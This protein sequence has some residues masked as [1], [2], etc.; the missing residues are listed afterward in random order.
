M[1]VSEGVA[2]QPL[3]AL[4]YPLPNEGADMMEQ[5]PVLHLPPG[6]DEE[7]DM[8][9]I[10]H[11]GDDEAV[12]NGSRLPSFSSSSAASFATY[13]QVAPQAETGGARMETDGG[14]ESLPNKRVRTRSPHWPAGATQGMSAGA[15][16]GVVQGQAQSQSL[17]PKSGCSGGV[18]GPFGDN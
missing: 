6:G 18:D 8:N 12:D 5:D 11:G 4:T 17:A 3:P 15:W 10:M 13:T 2:G 1:N 16:T 7:Y 9:T 14:G